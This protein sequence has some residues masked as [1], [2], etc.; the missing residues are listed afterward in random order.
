LE[1]RSE[2]VSG[3][4]VKKR[5]LSAAWFAMRLLADREGKEGRRVGNV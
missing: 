4:E 1:K 5:G 3:F 2:Q